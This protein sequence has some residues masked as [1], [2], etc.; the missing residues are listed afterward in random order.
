MTPDTVKMRPDVRCARLISP[1]MDAEFAYLQTAQQRGAV[2]DARI[3]GNG[4]D[5]RP[6]DKMPHEPARG[7][8][9][10]QRVAV[11]ADQEFAV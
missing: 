7:I 6:G 2:A 1:I 5:A 3:A 10:E 9:I 8:A 11:N 4:A